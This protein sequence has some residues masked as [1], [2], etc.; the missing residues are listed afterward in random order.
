MSK[1]VYA[2][3]PARIGSER[4]PYKNLALIDGEPLVSYAINAAKDANVFDKIYLN[5]DHK[6]FSDIAEEYGVDFYKRPEEFG[7]SS[8]STDEFLYDF[9]DSNPC[10]Y[11]AIVNPPSPLQPSD[12]VKEVVEHFIEHD[13][14]SLITVNEQQVHCVSDG[15][16]VNFSM[17]EKLAKTQSLAPL[18]TLVYSVMMWDTDAFCEEF[19]N[20]GYGLFCGDTEFYP[21]C[22]KSNI[23]VKYEEDLLLADAIKRGENRQNGNSLEYHD[24]VDD[25]N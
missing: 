20:E 5:S 11:V 3:V 1:S 8:T 16:P 21:V 18:H 12:E 9:I 22:D 24:I 7:S 14:D 2:M 19:E 17:D 13:L 15:E 10:D 23:L 4:L 25:I 6:V